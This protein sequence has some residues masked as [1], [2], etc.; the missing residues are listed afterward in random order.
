MTFTCSN[1]MSNHI[2]LSKKDIGQQTKHNSVRFVVVVAIHLGS[3][4]R[5]DMGARIFL[6]SLQ[7]L[8]SAILLVRRYVRQLQDTCGD[9]VNLKDLL[10]EPLQDVHRGSPSLSKMFI[11]VGMH[12]YINR[13]E[14]ACICVS[15]CIYTMFLKKEDI[16]FV[17]LNRCL[18]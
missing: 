8:I 9:F 13:S 18:L 6:N 14:C 3:C 2:R 10:P 15:I 1:A 5:L 16:E 7:N 4:H 11:E 12:T 17:T